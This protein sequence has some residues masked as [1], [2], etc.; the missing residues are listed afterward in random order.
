MK[1]ATITDVTVKSVVLVN[2][3]S[4]AFIYSRVNS[5]NFT[6]RML[7]GISYYNHIHR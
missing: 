4:V 1:D 2:E 7:A 5:N 6:V 3:A